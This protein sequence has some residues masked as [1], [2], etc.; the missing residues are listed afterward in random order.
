MDKIDVIYFAYS[1]KLLL[2]KFRSHFFIF[3]YSLP[4]KLTAFVI[5]EFYSRKNKMSGAQSRFI[6]NYKFSKDGEFIGSSR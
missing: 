1:G 2:I 3:N 6:I 5:S 4:I